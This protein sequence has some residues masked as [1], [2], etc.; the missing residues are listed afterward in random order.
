[1]SSLECPGGWATLTEA[2]HFAEGKH[3]GWKVQV[4]KT[5]FPANAD[6]LR[7]P[8]WDAITFVEVKPDFHG[9]MSHLSTAIIRWDSERLVLAL[10][11][12]GED[13]DALTCDGFSRSKK[14]LLHMA[15]ER[16]RVESVRALLKR[17]ASVNLIDELGFTGHDMV[18]EMIRM[19]DYL[20]RSEIQMFTMV[21]RAKLC[22]EFLP[23]AL[24]ANR[25]FGGKK[26]R[27]CPRVILQVIANFLCTAK[28][29]HVIGN[30]FDCAG[31]THVSY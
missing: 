9:A 6:W 8:R 14:S 29:D 23:L 16:H 5:F 2:I 1:M 27:T 30:I 3:P 21:R 26:S 31:K 20:C 12:C 25:R 4:G 24:C 22:Q 13:V 10:V 19:N 15:I 11:D 18:T 28:F 7:L 17:G